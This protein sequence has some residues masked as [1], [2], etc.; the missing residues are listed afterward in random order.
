MIIDKLKEMKD[1][2]IV[3]HQLLMEPIR[4][5]GEYDIPVN[6]TL[7]LVPEIKVIVHREG[8]TRKVVVPEPVREVV[9]ETVVVGAATAEASTD[10]LMNK[11][12]DLLL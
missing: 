5:L 2:E 3:R 7:D 12:T 11:G 6:L 9:V 10:F 1:I 8:E 4:N